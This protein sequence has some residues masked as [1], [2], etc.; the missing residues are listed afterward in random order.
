[1]LQ[2]ITGEKEQLV[3]WVW[4]LLKQSTLPA[5][6]SVKDYTNLYKNSALQL[7]AH[8][9]ETNGKLSAVSKRLKKNQ[10]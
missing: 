3:G 6:R 10:L 9:S 4:W 2:I 5:G 7:Q 8:S 1:M